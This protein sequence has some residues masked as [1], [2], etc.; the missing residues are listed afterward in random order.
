MN[1]YGNLNTQELVSVV[2]D[3][4][5]NPRLD[6]LAP[7]PKP[8]DWTPPTLIPLVKLP[9]PE[10]TDT[11]TIEPILVWYTD[12]VERDWT[13][14]PIA[15]DIL[16]ARTRKAK[17]DAARAEWEA[18]PAWIRGP[19]GAAHDAASK[20]VD[21]GDDEAAIALL[22]YAEPPTGYS[23]EQLETF[24]TVCAGLIE[25]IEDLTP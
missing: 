4:D 14:V 22:T 17:I 10:H 20:L 5:G 7:H 9:T 2:A 23:T 1:T 18:L 21:A 16:A 15:A 11:E 3:E 8:D 13:I 24:I 6:T 12:R 25:A 19:Y